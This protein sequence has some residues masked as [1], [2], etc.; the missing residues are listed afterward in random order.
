MP[1][2][3]A[4]ILHM[5]ENSIS[6]LYMCKMEEEKAPNRRPIKWTQQQTFHNYSVIL[7]KSGRIKRRYEDGLGGKAFTLVVLK[8]H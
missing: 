1:I 2:E 8:T 3:L 7:L 4:S 5:Y 6:Y